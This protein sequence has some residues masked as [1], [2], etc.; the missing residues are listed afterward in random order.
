MLTGDRS[1]APPSSSPRNASRRVPPGCFPMARSSELNRSALRQSGTFCSGDGIND[2]PCTRHVR[3]RRG[4]G[5]PSVRKR[6]LKWRTRLVDCPQPAGMFSIAAKTAWSSGDIV[7]KLGIK[8][9]LHDL[10]VVGLSGLWE[11]ASLT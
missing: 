4:N 1:K 8:G 3:C 11:A 5:R 7:M 9:L 10:G 6:P 2:A